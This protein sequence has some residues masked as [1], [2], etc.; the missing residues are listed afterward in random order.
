MEGFLEVLE[1]LHRLVG[2]DRGV[3]QRQREDQ[4]DRQAH[5]RHG[6]TW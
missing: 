5:R 4:D 3:I 6:R 2:R 1:D